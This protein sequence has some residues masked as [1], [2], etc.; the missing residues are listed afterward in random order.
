M[1]LLYTFRVIV[2]VPTTLE[3]TLEL[4]LLGTI[5]VAAMATVDIPESTDADDESSADLLN[6]GQKPYGV[7]G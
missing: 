6:Q 4:I 7:R 5:L 2:D 3:I 1:D